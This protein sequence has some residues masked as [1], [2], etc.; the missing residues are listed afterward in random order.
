MRW[1]VK[2]DFRNLAPQYITLSGL[3]LSSVAFGLSHILWFAGIVAGIAYG[4][5][6]RHT[7]NLWLAVVAHAITNAGL[8]V[9]ILVT[10]NW[11]FW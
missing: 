2:Q 5:L 3:L 8:G 4:L 7:S 6:Y 11:Q 10:H 9:W 1:I